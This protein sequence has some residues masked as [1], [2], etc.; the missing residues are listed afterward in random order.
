MHNLMQ[1]LQGTGGS[2][3]GGSGDGGSGQPNIDLMQALHR[4]MHGGGG[5][6]D[7]ITQ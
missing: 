6:P 2:G 1:H 3:G 4:R 7:C 5:Q